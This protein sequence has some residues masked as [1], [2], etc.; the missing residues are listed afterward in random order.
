MFGYYYYY[1]Y[2]YHCP[3]TRGLWSRQTE[4]SYLRMLIWSHF[5]KMAVDTEPLARACNY[6]CAHVLSQSRSS[7]S[8]IWIFVILM[9]FFAAWSVWNY[10]IAILSCFPS[11]WRGSLLE[12][13]EN[14]IFDSYLELNLACQTLHLTRISC[15]LFVTLQSDLAGFH[16]GY[17]SETK[18]W[19]S[20]TSFIPSLFI[21]VENVIIQLKNAVFL[22][23][24][25]EHLFDDLKD[26]QALRF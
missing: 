2:Y 5:L 25:K 21:Q 24:W 12:G 10:F 4:I 9:L 11:L 18:T 7:V 13:I 6:T 8:G 23:F 26:K 1:Y 22:S 16:R 14:L 20:K 3:E 19:Y 17:L 15:V